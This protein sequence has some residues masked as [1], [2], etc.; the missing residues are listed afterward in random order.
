LDYQDYNTADSDP[1]DTFTGYNVAGY[2]YTQPHAPRTIIDQPV[3]PGSTTAANDPRIKT[4][5]YQYDF[6]G[7]QTKT[8]QT[9]CN[10]P[11]ETLVPELLR[12]NLWDEENRLRAIDLNP[13]PSLESEEGT[14]PIAIYTYDAGGERIIK[15]NATNIALYENAKKVGSKTVNDF[16]LYPS[17]MLVV[18]P[19]ADSTGTMS[20][21][22]HY[23][24]G[25]QRVS[26]KIGTTTNLG[27]FLQD[28]TLQ[29]N[30]SGGAA[31][32]L[33][34]TSQ[35]QLIKAEAGANK[36]YTAFRMSYT[37][38]HGNPAFVPVAAFTNTGL[39]TEQYYFH[40]DHL[41]SSNYITNIA[42]EVSQHTEYFA[43]GETFVDE[44]KGS[45]NSPYKF[46]G[47]E[48][49]EESGLYYYG[50]RYYAAR[51]SIWLS[52]DN[53]F[54]KGPEYSPYCYAFN[55][56]IRFIDPDGN[57]PTPSEWKAFAI[58]AAKGA[59]VGFVAVAVVTVVV[60]TGGTAG[61]VIGYAAAAYGG[62]QTGKIA[63]E[64]GS[65][66]E[67]YSGRKLSSE[68]RFEK[69]GE[70]VG[71]F[72]GG[73]LGIKAG[74][75]ISGKIANLK[76]NFDFVANRLRGQDQLNTHTLG[77][78]D[79]GANSVMKS[80]GDATTVLKSVKNGE[81]K[82]LATNES[83]NRVYVENKNVTGYYNDNG[84]LVPTNLFL[85]KGG[86]NKGA[87]V[88]PIHPNTKKFK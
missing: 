33:V 7:N 25:S 83:Q 42:G 19:A 72:I 69:G 48:L 45:N 76:I 78:K 20:Y 24:A 63:Y 51:E 59:A 74:L 85:V 38:P 58:G 6:N 56:P 66:K 75:K 15:H 13:R 67:A 5:G 17:G 32:N 12:E 41:G 60:A 86:Q 18:R 46:N 27:T 11:G 29:E 49:D 14:H 65:G 36:V 22:K 28:W 9:V 70:L 43:F 2:T 82:I 44:H 21:T 23:F 31:I 1:L 84:N 4:K 30:A 88:V 87:T 80:L 57:W 77:G 71:G 35:A 79:V 52:V 64:V 53:E 73:G 26:S 68:E 40:P 39:E 62:Y 8:T 3:A 10:A 16:M 47:K 54:Q 37:T 34:G 61:L 50:A 81:G 55:N